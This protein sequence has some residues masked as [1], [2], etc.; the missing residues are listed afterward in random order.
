M[1]V[2]VSYELELCEVHTKHECEERAVRPSRERRVTTFRYRSSIQQFDT[3]KPIRRR[4]LK[5]SLRATIR[6]TRA[7]VARAIA[8]Y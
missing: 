2:R 6:R 3:R 1:F 8:D 7:V 5:S 4:V